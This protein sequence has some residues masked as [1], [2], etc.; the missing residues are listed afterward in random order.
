[1][2][3]ETKHEG[4]ERILFVNGADGFW[5]AEQSMRAIALGLARG[6]TRV[7]MVVRDP[8]WRSTMAGEET[9]HVRVISGGDGNRERN[10]RYVAPILG[11]GP[12]TTVVVFDL[13]L[14]P[15]AALLRPWLRRRG[16]RLVVDLHDAPAP[17]QRLFRCIQ[18]AR[19]ADACVC[20]SDFVARQV[21]RHTSTFVVKRPIVPLAVRPNPSSRLVAGIVGRLDPEKRLEFAIEALAQAAEHALFDV[22]IRGG[23]SWGASDYAPGLLRLAAERLGDRVEYEGV[24]EHDA[25]LDGI[26]L[27]LM[28][29]EREPSGR[30]VAEA[31]ASG[32]PVVVP[33]TGGVSEFVTNGRNGLTYDSGSVQ[34]AA[35]AL[36]SLANDFDLRERVRRGGLATAREEYNPDT[37]VEKYSRILRSDVWK[38]LY[39]DGAV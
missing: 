19:R 2:A 11:A 14:V 16:A 18:L 8:G 32:V 5:G 27:L 31:Q 12:K 3:N 29:N 39:E 26:D 22:V 36:A 28:A 23:P 34:S 17:D 20:V 6:G 10:L 1:M 7:D 25:A 13:R 9:V 15:V 35:Q 38:G 4:A 30:T 21:E 33:N 24:V 37:Q